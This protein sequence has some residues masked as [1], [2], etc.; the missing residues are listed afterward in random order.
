MGVSSL[1]II[2]FLDHFFYDGMAVLHFGLKYTLTP[3][4]LL[5]VCGHLLHLDFL[6][7]LLLLPAAARVTT[8]LCNVLITRLILEHVHR[9]ATRALLLRRVL[10]ALRLLHQFAECARLARASQAPLLIYTLPEADKRARPPLLVVPLAS[11]RAWALAELWQG[12]GG[13][14]GRAQVDNVGAEERCRLHLR[15]GAIPT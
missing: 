8:I 5:L 11:E 10:R 12:L 1:L 7:A 13:F 15:I 14:S 6:V 3:L 9:I 4:V 2:L